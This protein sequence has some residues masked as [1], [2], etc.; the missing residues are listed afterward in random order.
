M[1]FKVFITKVNYLTVYDS[2]WLD[3]NQCTH[4]QFPTRNA[5]FLS[6]CISWCNEEFP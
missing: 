3:D 4:L 1:A 6:K 5:C 2:L